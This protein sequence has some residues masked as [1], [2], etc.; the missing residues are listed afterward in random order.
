MELLNQLVGIQG[1]GSS[2]C[3]ILRIKISYAVSGQSLAIDCVMHAEGCV[4]NYVK[5]KHVI[6]TWP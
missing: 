3:L 4:H 2:N 6:V 5:E 1:K